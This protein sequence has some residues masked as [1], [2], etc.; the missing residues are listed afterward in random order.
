MPIFPLLCLAVIVYAVVQSNRKLRTAGYG[1]LALA[2]SVGVLYG[3]TV[4]LRLNAEIMGHVAV[5][6]MFVIAAYVA[7]T[8]SRATRK[9]APQSDVPPG[10]ASKP[11]T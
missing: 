4:G 8:H 3:L 10:D 1:V 11:N 7:W 6:V 2:V 9:S 5:P